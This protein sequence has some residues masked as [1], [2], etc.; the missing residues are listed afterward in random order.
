MLQDATDN[1]FKILKILSILNLI[2][3]VQAVFLFFHFILKS[4]GIRILNQLV[5]LL[6]LCF[7]IIVFNTYLNLSDYNFQGQVLQDIANNV[8]WFI[9][10]SLY[11]YVIYYQ[12]KPSKRFILL[13]TIPYI[14]PALIDILFNWQSFEE[15]IPFVGFT[16]MSI[17]LFIAI[18]YCILHYKMAQQFFSWILPSIVA[19][20]LIV[21]INYS[22]YILRYIGIELLPRAILASFT[23]LLV[24]PVFYLAYK[25]MNSTN[26]FGIVPK[27][28]KTSPISKKK[29]DQ[30]L[31][32][33][34]LVMQSDKLYLNPELTLQDFAYSIGIPS[35]YV[36]Q[37]INKN[38]G[39]SFTD[40]LLQFRLEEVKKNLISPDKQHLTIYGIAQDSGFASSSRFNHL[41]KKTTGLTPGQ[42]QKQYK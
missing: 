32:K 41:F 40:Y 31:Q 10:P 23:S 26:D 33:I 27:K 37:V 9:G 3:A 7:T 15:V 29:S 28:Y 22:L 24:F 5:A 8:M 4:K 34:K 35:K 14:I 13:N 39:L 20:A 38:L 25:E 19:I 17:Y 42:Y 36:S 30:Y 6:C 16:Q 11:L 18:K 2:I 1:Y 12:K 21:A